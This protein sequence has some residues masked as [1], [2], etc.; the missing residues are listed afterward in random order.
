MCMQASISSMWAGGSA[1]VQHLLEVWCEDLKV[2]PHVRG[3]QLLCSSKPNLF[4]QSDKMLTCRM[5]DIDVHAH[6]RVAGEPFACASSSHVMSLNTSLHMISLS[7][8][9][10]ASTACGHEIHMLTNANYMKALPAPLFPAQLDMQAVP[11]D[12]APAH[13]AQLSEHFSG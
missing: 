3:I 4:Q 9:S 1:G 2:E 10:S 11:S 5:Q 8:F 7:S 13:Q 6:C 12:Q